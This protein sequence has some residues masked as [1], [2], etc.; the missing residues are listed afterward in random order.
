MSETLVRSLSGAVFG[1]LVIGLVYYSPWTNALLWA[2]ASILAV[3]EFKV[4]TKRASL[5]TVW[6]FAAFVALWMCMVIG[7][8]WQNAGAYEPSVLLSLVFT[9]WAADSGAYFVGKPLGKHK[10]MPS[11]S[12]GKSWEGL[13][14]GAASAAV[15]AYFLWGASFVWVG[16]LLAVLGTAGDL[17][18]SSWKRRNGLKDSGA[19][20]PGHGGVLDRFDGFALTVPVYFVLLSL[21]PFEFALKAILP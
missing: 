7:L 14:G 18:E 21:L 5:A 9:I 4:G 17:M 11:V 20:M 19:I 3:R 2:S 13:M 12:P 16:P 15:V 10:L 1:V 8:P 6:G